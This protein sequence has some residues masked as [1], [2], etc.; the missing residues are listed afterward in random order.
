MSSRLLGRS[1]GGADLVVP[2]V[3]A[4]PQHHGRAFFRRQVV[5][6]RGEVLERRQ[7]VL[8]AELRQLV[9]RPPPAGVVDDDPARD[10]EDPG[11]QM[12]AVLETRIGSEGAEER[13][14]EGVLR[15]LAAEPPAEKPED[16]VA[17]GFVEGLEGRDHSIGETYSDPGM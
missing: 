2:E 3:V 7:A 11:A 15:P 14:L 1:E 5:R 8:G 9:L 16:F 13:L 10:R 17:V 4:V 12:V 6:E